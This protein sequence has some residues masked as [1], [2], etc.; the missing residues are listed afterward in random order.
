VL[1][2]EVAEPVQLHVCIP[3]PVE[4]PYRKMLQYLFLKDMLK[5][6]ALLKFVF[7]AIE[8]AF[9][10]TKPLSATALAAFQKELA[11]ALRPLPTGATFSFADRTF[12]GDEIPVLND[13]TAS[14]ERANVDVQ[15]LLGGSDKPR[16]AA[17][18]K[19]EEAAARAE[20]KLAESKAAEQRGPDPRSGAK[21]PSLPMR[22]DPPDLATPVHSG[23]LGKSHIHILTEK[24]TER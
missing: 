5:R 24:I 7:D 8:K 23:S 3:A 9:P 17:K 10:G 19:L 14:L 15:P 16:R 1:S 4:E 21:Q 22:S 20:Q 2:V 13:L 11:A 6:D 18:A 12:P